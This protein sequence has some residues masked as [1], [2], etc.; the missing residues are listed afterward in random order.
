[1]S[2]NQSNSPRPLGEGPGVRAAARDIA[3]RVQNLSKCYQIYEKPENRLKQSIYPRLQ[4][5]AGKAPKQYFREFWA[6]KDVSVEIRKGETVGIIGRNGSGKS[7]LLQMICG[8]LTPTSGTVETNGRIAALLELGSGFNPEFS[9][10]ENVYMNAAVLGLS[11]EEVDERFNDIAAFADIGEF[12]DQSVKTYS[13]GMMVRLAFAVVVHVDADILVVDEALSVGDVFFQQKCMRFLGVFQKRGGTILFVSHDTGAVTALCSAAILLSREGE[14]YFITGTTD[15]ICRIYLDKLYAER[16]LPQV[17][18]SEPKISHPSQPIFFDPS[19]DQVYP[20]TFEGKEQSENIIRIFQFRQDTESF[21]AGGLK[22][23]DV[24]FRDING[25]RLSEILGGDQTCLCVTAKSLQQ[26]RS[27]AFGF[28]L[29]DRLGQ[30]IVAEGTDLSFRCY[31]LV[32]EKDEIISVE[33]SFL[34]PI[35][36]QGEYTLNV[37]VAEGQGD[38]HIQHHWIHDAIV[39]QSLKSRLVHGI[40]GLQG[41]NIKMQIQKPT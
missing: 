24:W 38:D 33:F 16:S 3:I 34:M 23:R 20:D 26:V 28:M 17:R 6:L 31:K 11:K 35:L 10:R 5:L 37:A 8:T 30:Y 29:K 21:G 36:I 4:R 25:N 2:S 7:T 13:S 27:P 22:I 15:E 39:I 14:R 18:D 41:L 32:F 19:N 9:G 1:M 12:I 40:T